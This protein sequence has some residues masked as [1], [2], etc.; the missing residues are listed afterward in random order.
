M[1]IKSILKHISKRIWIIWSHR[2]KFLPHNKIEKQV[3]IGSAKQELPPIKAFHQKVGFSQNAPE[4]NPFYLHNGKVLHNLDELSNELIT[5]DKETFNH[6]V[7]E[8]KNDFSRWINDIFKA[9]ELA[10]ELQMT[11]DM[12]SIREI[13]E[14]HRLQTKNY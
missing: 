13:L 7:N 3:V 8:Q 2:N 5:M 9:P 11:K 1:G 10:G 6:H 12:Y 4:Q 14:K